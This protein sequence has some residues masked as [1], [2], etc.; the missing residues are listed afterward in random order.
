MTIGSSVKVEE[1]CFVQCKGLTTSD[2][3]DLTWTTFAEFPGNL[4]CV[5]RSLFKKAWVRLMSELHFYRYLYWT[6]LEF[7]RYSFYTISEKHTTCTYSITTCN[8]YIV[9][10]FRQN[11][12]KSKIPLSIF[13]FPGLFV[14]VFLIER[15]GRKFTMGFEF[16]VFSVFVLLAN[17]CTS[18]LVTLFTNLHLCRPF[19]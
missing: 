17:I 6:R 7:C 10:S 18:R 14:T 8:M 1:P 2:Y 15:I 5:N 19:V 16:F 4:L 9:I 12:K 11:F 13:C 3:V